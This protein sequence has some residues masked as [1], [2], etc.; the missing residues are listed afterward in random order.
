MLGE[1]VLMLGLARL[2]IVL[3]PFRWLV[4]HPPTTGGDPRGHEQVAPR[5][6]RALQRAAHITPWRSKCLE[7]AVAGHWM[8][9]R[10]GLPNALYLG[11]N[12]TGQHMEAHAWL[13]SG[14][15]IITGR[16]GMENYRVVAC[17]GEARR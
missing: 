7:Q 2:A 10:R 12:K 8:L 5:I 14:E 1:A 11:V 17:F 4:A 6:G 9:R 15:H 16:A 3:L 13:R